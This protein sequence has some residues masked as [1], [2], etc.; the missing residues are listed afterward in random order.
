MISDT[1]D[2][3]YLCNLCEEEMIDNDRVICPFCKIEICETCFQYSLTMELKNSTC[4]YC[5]ERLSLEFI[6]SNNEND[7]C[8]KIFIPFFENLCLETE[9]NLLPSTVNKYKKYLE[10]KNIKAKIKDLPSNKN[11]EFMLKKQIKKIKTENKEIYNIELNKKIIDRNLIKDNLQKKLSDLENKKII[12]KKE[13]TIYISKCTYQNCRGYINKSYFCDLCN[14]SIC[15]ACMKIKANNEE[16]I[17]N[18]DDIS[19][20][21]FIKESSK[22]CPKCYVSIFKISGCNQMFCTNCKTVFDWISLKID[23]GSVHNQ[24]YFEWLTTLNNTSNEQRLENI[25][26]GN[27]VDIYPIGLSKIDNNYINKRKF[28]KIFLLNR[29]FHG[30]I[31]NEIRLKMK[32]NFE[33]YRIE[34]L[35]NQLSEELWKKK[36]A[37]DTIES[38]KIKSIIEILELYITITSDYIRKFAYEQINQKDFFK[39]YYIFFNHFN[40]CLENTCIIY[41]GKIPDCINKK[42]FNHDCNY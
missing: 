21:L 38:E 11:I 13:E 27:I 35:D 16:H 6:L 40:K 32:N 18:K 3:N 22:P 5:H 24:H 7:W 42:L 26:C 2:V 30:E 10:I 36:I 23:T 34:F 29:E 15:K 12:V 37:K 4:I 8:K 14:N 31:I 17:C 33:K 41:G 20:A 28:T 1:K 25:A 19:S 39:Q 9:K